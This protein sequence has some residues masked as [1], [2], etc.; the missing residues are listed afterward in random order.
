MLDVHPPHHSAHTW[1]DFFIH[2]ATIVVG[3]LIAVG[4]EQLVEHIHQHYE[5]RET[6]E[7]LDREYAGNQAHVAS[8]SEEWLLTLARLR[9][10]L[11]V[12]QF[13]RQHPG[14]PQTQLPGDL[15][16]RAAP[17]GFDTAVWNAAEKN[18]ITRLM[19]LQ[20]A[21]RHAELYNLLDVMS[22]QGLDNWN[23]LNDAHRF[24]LLDP[25]PT[26]L[27]PP[28]LDHVIDLVDVALEKH[29]QIGYSFGRLANEFPDMPHI[30]TW[31]R[32]IRLRPSPLDLDPH[33]MA[34][35]H[36]LTDQRLSAA[37]P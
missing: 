2:I 28:Q 30:I 8:A 15:R 19:P 20:E 34:A 26:H 32:M 35:A 31:A 24:D 12:L 37:L 11:V 13:I 17:H 33:G 5:L 22:Q 23:A 6:R 18:G 3:L 14:V 16:W 21:N 29:I 36:K 9:N 10:N 4:L 1:R 7:A 27:S 25:D